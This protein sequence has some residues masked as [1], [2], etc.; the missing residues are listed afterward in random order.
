MNGDRLTPWVEGTA[1]DL[2]ADALA[3]EVKASPRMVTS[4]I[5]DG[6]LANPE[7][8]KT[9]AHGSDPRVFPREQ[10][11]LFTRLLEARER[12]PLGRIP[13]CSSGRPRIA[14]QVLQGVSGL[15]PPWR[16]SFSAIEE[17]NAQAVGRSRQGRRAGGRS[18]GATEDRNGYP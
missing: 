14:T 3:L 2:V 11:E 4:W 17:R 1:A 8:R 15:G 7:P 13:Q 18:S 12:S 10:R 9:S 5:E 16:S 6:L